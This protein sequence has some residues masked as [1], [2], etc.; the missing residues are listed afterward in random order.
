MGPPAS[1]PQGQRRRRSGWRGGAG[2][3][4]KE[5]SG[6]H[7]IH[8]HEH[9][10]REHP[11][12]R[13]RMLETPVERLIP[14]LAAPTIASMMVT[15]IYN[16][17]D[18]YFVSQLSTSASGA[19][20]VVF[21]VMSAIQAVGFTVG[22]GSG[23][24]AARMLGQERQ[25]EADRISSSAVLLALV[26]GSLLAALG[27]AFMPSIVWL[28]GS[29]ET[30]YPYALDYAKYIILGCPVMVV[31]F[32]LNNLLR[33]QGKASLSVIGLG[34]GGLLNLVLDPLLIFG[35]DMGISGAAIATLMSQ[36]VSMGIL[37]SFFLFK[38]SE[39]R[40]S[41]ACVARS[42][43][44]YLAILKQGM[45]SFFRQGVMS[46]ATMA[47]NWN[48]RAFGDAAVAAMAIVSK[49]FMFIQSITIGFGQGFQPV[50]G[51]N[52]GAGRMDRVKRA[53]AFSIKVC[54]II[55]TAAAVIGLIF[56]PQI[57]RLFRDDP[58]VVAIGG[59]A[60]R[61]QCITLPLTAVLTFANMFFQSLGKSGRATIL[62]I[63]RQGMF[64]PLVFLLTWQFGLT[65][66]E[67]TQACADLVAF[68]ISGGIMLHYF[69]R[70]F[71]RDTV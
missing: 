62:A 61:Y 34:T 45:P 59:R 32:T 12:Q 70:E 4:E 46:A 27:I 68:L 53:L 20:G 3:G 50:L 1:A 47:L 33:W 25:E 35:F 23:S 10:P 37:A 52:Y 30:I 29:T 14:V 60:F 8:F 7:W 24:I 11:D 43:R 69:M 15:S 21:P 17:A 66:L 26:L 67:L 49:V 63:C 40:V 48:A 39:L 38:K 51:Y 31:A 18:T 13:T 36:C 2:R 16:M 5:V 54:T 64:F 65:G 9:R 44:T 6:L 56:A 57:V 58:T 71:D 42:P 41:P 22:M 28:L 19:V 55:L